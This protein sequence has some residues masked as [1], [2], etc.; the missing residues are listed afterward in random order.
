MIPDSAIES[1]LAVLRPGLAETG[2]DLSA[3][4]QR[5]GPVVEVILAATSEACTDCVVPDD[6]LV[7]VLE[8][9][10][11]REDPSLVR[12]DLIKRGFGKPGANH[13]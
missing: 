2:F 3:G 6:V 4:E 1:A 12:V 7:Q 9:V 5:E 11:R 13:D 8:D 10:I